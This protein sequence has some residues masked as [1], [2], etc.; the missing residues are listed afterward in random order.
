MTTDPTDRPSCPDPIECSHEAALGEAQQEIRRLKLMVDE[1]GQGAGLLGEKLREARARIAELEARNTP[2][3]RERAEAVLPAP[4]D[5]ADVLR[6][7]AGVAEAEAAFLYDD[8]GQKAAA[9][10][11]YVADRLRRLADETPQP[12]PDGCTCAS[13]GEEFRP[14]GHYRDC[15]AAP[16]V[17]QPGEEADRG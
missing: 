9:G 8:M 17:A 12:E 7:A 16:A 2:T 13:A 11:R 5:R 6:E 1:Y 10:A 14:A 3:W 15:P 4:V